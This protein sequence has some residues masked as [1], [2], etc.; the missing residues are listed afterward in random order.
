MTS[1]ATSFSPEHLLPVAPVCSAWQGSRPP[2]PTLWPHGSPPTCL[3]GSPGLIP[4][5]PQTRKWRCRQGQHPVQTHCSS[6]RVRTSY[7]DSHHQRALGHTKSHAGCLPLTQNSVQPCKVGVIVHIVLLVGSA[8]PLCEAQRGYAVYLGLHR[9]WGSRDLSQGLSQCS[10]SH[11]LILWAQGHLPTGFFCHC[12]HP[13]NLA[14]G[15][16]VSLAHQ[17]GL[18]LQG[19]IPHP[20]VLQKGSRP[21]RAAER[22]GVIWKERCSP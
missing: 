22:C 21:F 20:V 12:H 17:S 11:L 7:D 18:P 15:G 1:T 13:E 14:G 3:W 8:L 9:K 10:L 16:I 2:Q 6:T 5:S 4:H 19:S